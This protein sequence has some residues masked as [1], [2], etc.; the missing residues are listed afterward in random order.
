MPP[1]T[2]VHADGDEGGKGEEEKLHGR[3][4][5][6]SSCPDVASIEGWYTNAKI[7]RTS[8]APN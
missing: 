3:I 5:S 2:F 1:E 8:S 4:I 6:H 7:V